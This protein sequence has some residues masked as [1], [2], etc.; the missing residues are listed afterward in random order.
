M[1]MDSTPSLLTGFALPTYETWEQSTTVD[2]LLQYTSCVHMRSLRSLGL[3]Q[4]AATRCGVHRKPLA[5]WRGCA[6]GYMR[7]WSEAASNAHFSLLQQAKTH[8]YLTKA[9]LNKACA[10]I[11]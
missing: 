3:N 1:A 2:R 7:G 4:Q 8:W 10:G 9:M 11:R 5:H 6:T